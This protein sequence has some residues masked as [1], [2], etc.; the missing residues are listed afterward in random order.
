MA[1]SPSLLNSKRILGPARGSSPGPKKGSPQRSMLPLCQSRVQNRLLR[2][3]P[4]QV[5]ESLAPVMRVVLFDKGQILYSVGE[6]IE[7]LFFIE[8]GM[9]VL[10]RSMGDGRSIE[11]ATIGRDGVVGLCGVIGR[12]SCITDAVGQ[13]SG[14][15]FCI[16]AASFWNAVKNSDRARHVMW[17]YSQYWMYMFAQT[18]A[19]NGLHSLEERICRWLLRA[20]DI[21]HTDCFPVT[22]E[23]LATILGVQRAGVSLAAYDLRRRGLINY[24]RGMISILDR[25]ALELAAC[26]CRR[27]ISSQLT[28]LFPID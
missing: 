11:I 21:V 8:D 22:H 10:S 13:I 28:E 16:S 26:E 9:V 18:A 15:A 6:S 25:E 24:T 19:C 3:L 1:L 14:D 20:Q 27:E 17:N 7:N 12:N 23:S 5:F 2:G 4:K